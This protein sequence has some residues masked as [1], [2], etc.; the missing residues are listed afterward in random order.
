MHISDD[1]AFYLMPTRI[2]DM[3]HPLVGL[4]FVDLFHL[5]HQLSHSQLKIVQLVLGNDL[6]VVDSMLANVNTQVNPL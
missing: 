2:H 1:P 4:F 3:A 6:L 5:V